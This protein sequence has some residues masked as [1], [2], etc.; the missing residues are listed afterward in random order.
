MKDDNQLALKEKVSSFLEKKRIDFLTLT[1]KCRKGNEKIEKTYSFGAPFG[2][3][4]PDYIIVK[5]KG[6]IEVGI[7]MID[8]IAKDV[9]NYL[10]KH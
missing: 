8:I 10:S 6:G 4:T 1:L 9:D 5:I 7:M 3:Y 2:K